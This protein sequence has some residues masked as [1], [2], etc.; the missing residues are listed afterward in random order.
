[1]PGPDS[2]MHGLIVPFIMWSLGGV[3]VNHPALLN[4]IVS[5][6]ALPMSKKMS[7]TLV[8]CLKQDIGSIMVQLDKNA[9]Y[10]IYNP[11]STIAMEGLR[12]F[13]NVHFQVWGFCICMGSGSNL[14]AMQNWSC[15]SALMSPRHGEAYRQIHSENE[16]DAQYLSGQRGYSSFSLH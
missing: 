10:Q 4:R 15:S 12:G 9:P 7:V 11:E 5:I 6:W 14:A 8:I 13:G 16:G 2:E 1:M 3:S